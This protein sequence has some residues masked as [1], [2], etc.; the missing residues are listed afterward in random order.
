MFLMKVPN[1]PK[2]HW[3]I[4]LTICLPRVPPFRLVRSKK[5]HTRTN[6]LGK[7]DL[8]ASRGWACCRNVTALGLRFAAVSGTRAQVRPLYFAAHLGRV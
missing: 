1:N 4:I 3:G 7:L 6:T 2:S 8:P 5:T